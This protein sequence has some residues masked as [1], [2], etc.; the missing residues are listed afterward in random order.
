MANC[1]ES[2]T[3]S[4][5][6][7]EKMIDAESLSSTDAFK[8]GC[9]ADEDGFSDISENELV[10]LQEEAM[11]DSSENMSL[12]KEGVDIQ[13]SATNLCFIIVKSEQN[14][15][16]TALP[17][18]GEKDENSDRKEE[19]AEIVQRK[20]KHLTQ[21]PLEKYHMKY[22]WVTHLC[23]QTWCEQQMVY[24]FELPELIQPEKSKA[25]NTG[26]SI[27]LARELEVQ[28]VVSVTTQTREDS[29]AVKFLNI[30]SM[31]PILQSGG[32]IREFPVFG[33]L[34]GVFLVGVIDQL[35]YNPK[36][37]LELRELKTR[38]SPSLPSGG[39]KRSHHFQVSLYKLLFDGMMS[40]SLQT[41]LFIQH[42]HLKP[43]QPLGSQVKEHGMK[44]GFIASTFKEIL[45]LTCL[46][47][48][49]SDIPMID[50]LK[51]EYC[52]QENNSSLGCELVHFV[53]ETSVEQL[54]FYLA[55][56]KGLRETQGVDI[57]EAWKCRKCSFA[58]ICEWRASKSAVSQTKR[59]K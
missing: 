34:G 37:E 21:T 41:D 35:G 3:P 20:R 1:T 36:G 17:H 23:S 39:Q 19:S 49:F 22:L 42:L 2:E 50:S 52:Y 27:H 47:L 24:E 51:I 57:E 16:V 30:L 40:G 13:F 29:W 11:I 14:S 55:Y 48:A 26:S 54:N 44:V 25:M 32:C 53:K 56:W 4:A 38:S 5:P 59:L 46:N 10:M 28:D 7:K 45:D 33:V 18:N 15:D 31:I 8:Q 43:E 6:G 12:L 9:G 58:D